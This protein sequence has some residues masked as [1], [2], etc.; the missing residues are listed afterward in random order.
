ML[1][2]GEVGRL[3]FEEHR[4]NTRFHGLGPECAISDL[5]SAYAVQREYLDLLRKANGAIDRKSTRL[6]SSHKTVSRMPSSA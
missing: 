3:L 6:N 2:R 5:A 4:N 1:T